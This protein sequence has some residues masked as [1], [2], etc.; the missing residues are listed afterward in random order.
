M[1]IAT[2]AQADAD[3]ELGDLDGDGVPDNRDDDPLN[4][5]PGAAESDYDRLSDQTELDG[6]DI[7]DVYFAA[8]APVGGVGQ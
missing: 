3:V 8:V 5:P 1:A 4:P 2:A 7:T 6:W